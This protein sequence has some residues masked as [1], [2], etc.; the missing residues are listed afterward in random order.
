MKG[1]LCPAA[2]ALALIKTPASAATYV[3]LDLSVIVASGLQT[4][5]L[6]LPPLAPG[7]GVL[8]QTTVFDHGVLRL[9]NPTVLT[10]DA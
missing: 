10:I 4:A 2:L 3:V 7:F 8:L 5:A 6:N 1:T 9:S